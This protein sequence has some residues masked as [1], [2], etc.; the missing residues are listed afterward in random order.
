LVTPS[1]AYRGQQHYV[2]RILVALAG[3]LVLLIALVRLWPADWGGPRE[4]LYSASGTETIQI[5]EIQPTSQSREK[6]P[7]PPAPLPPIVIPND[8]IDEVVPLDFTDSALPIDE[9][10]EDAERQ[11]GT[12]AQLEAAQRPDVN[13]RLLRYVE[14]EYT[15]AARRDDVQAEVVIEVQVNAH[16][17]VEDATVL[18]RTL[19]DEEGHPMQTV[20]TL[21]YGLEAAALD[22]ARN[23]LFRPARA[24]G[25]PVATRTTLTIRFGR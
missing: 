13:A 5:E 1:P 7:P 25:E 21:G 8:A 24:N 9:P 11:E 10:G 4:V 22:A 19:L 15:R 14:P 17:R 16:G 6:R 3:T 23:C 2:L 12:T 20:D 18:R